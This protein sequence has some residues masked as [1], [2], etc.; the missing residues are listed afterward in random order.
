MALALL[1]IVT[2]F[3][4]LL[5]SAERFVEGPSRRLSRAR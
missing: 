1:A 2:G 3:A 5:W 4:L